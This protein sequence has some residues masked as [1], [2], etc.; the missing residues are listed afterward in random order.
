MMA[1]VSSYINF[2]IAD[3]VGGGGGEGKGVGVILQYMN[4]FP[5]MVNPEV[6]AAEE[7]HFLK[8]FSRNI[9]GKCN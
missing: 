9:Y 2:I 1:L 7:F 6:A 5:I 3:G 8:I 4:L